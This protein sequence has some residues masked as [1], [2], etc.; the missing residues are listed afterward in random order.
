M[1]Y[2]FIILINSI[3][4]REKLNKITE[5]E[6]YEQTLIPNEYVNLSGEDAEKFRN[7]LDVLDE[8]EDVQAV[9]HNAKFED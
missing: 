1:K 4:W 5:F 8:I 2:L 9:Y 6:T 3:Y 7:L